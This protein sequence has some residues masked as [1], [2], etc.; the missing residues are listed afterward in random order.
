MLNERNC[1][2]LLAGEKEKQGFVILITAFYGRA[3]YKMLS[4]RGGYAT[5]KTYAV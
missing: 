1:D 4:W 2:F 3:I 5:G